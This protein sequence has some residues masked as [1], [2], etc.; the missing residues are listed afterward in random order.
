MVRRIDTVEARAKLPPRRPPYWVRLVPGTHLGYRKMNAGAP[1]TWI[2]RMYEPGTQSRQQ[3]SLGEFAELAAHERYAAAKRAAESLAQHLEQGGSAEAVTVRKA[4]DLYVEHLRAEGKNAAADDAEARF[5]RWVHEDKIAKL[6]MR[7][8]AKHHL[9]TWRQALIAAPVIENPYADEEDQRTRD[10][11]PA[12]VN[13]DMAVLRAALNL[14]M[15]GGAVSTDAAWRMTLRAIE[16][17]ERR[18]ELYLDRAQRQALIAKAP[19]DVAALL[20][21]LALVPLRPGALAALTVGD[22]ERRTGVLKVGTDKAGADRKIMLPTTTLAFFA[23]Q[24]A[25]KLPTAPLFARADGKAW[26][27]DAWKKPIKA[28]AAAAELPATVTAYSLRHSVIT[29]LITAGLDALTVARLSGTSIA[30]IERHYGHLRARHAAD[31]L[32]MLAL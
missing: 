7:K 15:E 27:K 14:A 31:A 28:A 6:D 29:D 19:A 8:L 17:A 22:L 11:A 9:R 3:A 2:V 1:G 32:A 23:E 21:G 26:D 25:S 18:R 30:M 13:R 12:S 16:N 20:R 10:R 24:C 4:C 5:R